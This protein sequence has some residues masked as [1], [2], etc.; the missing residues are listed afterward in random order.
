MYNRIVFISVLLILSVWSCEKDKHE[1]T[2]TCIQGN[3]YDYLNYYKID[4][5]CTSEICTNYLDIWKEL[6]KE[7][8]NLSDSF[9]DEHVILCQSYTDDWNEGV[10]FR[11]CYK[12][13][14]DWAIAYGC[15][16]FMIKIN[17]GSN[18]YPELPRNEY[19]SGNDIKFSVNQNRFY[20][21][22][23][24]VS[25]SE[26]NFFSMDEALN[27]L[28]EDANVNTLCVSNIYVDE[29]TGNLMLEAWAEYENEEN[30]CIK[31]KIDL[32]SGET[33]VTDTPCYIVF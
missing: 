32:V 11:I 7:K 5:I 20:S 8:N 24:F 6:F 33:E 3:A 25:G 28:I 19:L 4:S 31:G 23:G 14:M 15:D 2:V 29:T 18:L 12:I 13:Q 17:D 21:R 22:I 9:F 26:I 27:R 16:K 1:R 30:S 10:S